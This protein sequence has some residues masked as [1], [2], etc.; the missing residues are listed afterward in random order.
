MLI[1]QAEIV[2]TAELSMPVLSNSLLSSCMNEEG[3]QE[4]IP[5]RIS[6][7]CPW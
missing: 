5:L 4:G 2:V 6:L 7:S 3:K 1:V